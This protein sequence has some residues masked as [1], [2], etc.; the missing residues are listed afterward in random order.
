MTR[1]RQWDKQVKQ[2][3]ACITLREAK[4]LERIRRAYAFRSDYEFVGACLR[5]CLNALD[6]EGLDDGIKSLPEELRAWFGDMLYRSMLDNK[7]HPI[8]GAG[9]FAEEPSEGRVPRAWVD[10][11]VSKY[12]E[13]LFAEFAGREE[14][15]RAS[16]GYTP[17]DIFQDTVFRLYNRPTQHE[18][19]EDW[20]AETLAK[21]K[22]PRAI[23]EAERQDHKAKTQTL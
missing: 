8:A 6:N 13:R 9:L 20:E 11:F 16:D 3:K 14:V 23:T 18:R 12:Y 17:I 15:A 4:R 5:V 21:F 22:C 1:A 10:R 19:Y 2:V 7:P